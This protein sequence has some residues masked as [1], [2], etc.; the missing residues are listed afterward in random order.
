MGLAFLL[1]ACANNLADSFPCKYISCLWSL[2]WSNCIWGSE[3][4]IT[5]LRKTVQSSALDFWNRYFFKLTLR[6]DCLELCIWTVALKTI[7][8]RQYYKNTSHV[9]TRAL[10]TIWEMPSFNLTLNFSFELR[11]CMFVING[12]YTKSKRL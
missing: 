11:F 12:Y 4:L 1:A 7:L 9:Q 6:N 5:W 8:I 3:Y 2:I 10:N